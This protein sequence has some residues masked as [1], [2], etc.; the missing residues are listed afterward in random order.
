[1]VR[2]L[3]CRDCG[4]VYG[5]DEDEET[6]VTAHYT[7]PPYNYSLANG[8]CLACWL[9]PGWNEGDPPVVKIIRD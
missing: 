3:I 2:D 1:M 9:C 7:D 6:A 4:N 5:S 8:Y